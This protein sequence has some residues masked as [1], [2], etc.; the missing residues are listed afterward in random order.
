[1]VRPETFVL[2]FLGAG[3]T[4][5]LNLRLFK[6]IV[7]ANGRAAP[8]TTDGPQGAY[9]LPPCSPAALP[10]LEILPVQMMTLALAKIKHITAGSFTLGSKVTTTE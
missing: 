3:E 8:V 4:R 10:L 7:G 5:P 2:V 1:M 6:D 9:A